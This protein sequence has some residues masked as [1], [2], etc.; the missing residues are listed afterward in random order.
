MSR[1]GGLRRDDDFSY[2]AAWE[3]QAVGR[4]A[5]LHKEPLAFEYV[6]PTQRSYK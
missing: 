1:G 6:K 4:P 3:H 5:V 2:V